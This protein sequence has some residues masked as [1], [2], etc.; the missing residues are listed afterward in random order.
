MPSGLGY[1]RWRPGRR[2]GRTGQHLQPGGLDCV[3]F[4]VVSLDFFQGYKKWITP[5]FTGDSFAEEVAVSRTGLFFHD[6]TSDTVTVLAAKDGYGRIYHV[7]QS[8]TFTVIMTHN[9]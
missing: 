1:R 3:S 9:R 4:S 7:N 5:G 6:E 2:L 8:Y